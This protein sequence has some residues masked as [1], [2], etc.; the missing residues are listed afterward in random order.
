MRTPHSSRARLRRTLARFN[1]AFANPVMRLVAGWLPPLAIVQHRGRMTGREYATPVIAFGRSDGLVVGV[2]GVELADL[3]RRPGLGVAPAT[4]SGA[5]YSGVAWVAP[6][7][8][9]PLV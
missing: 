3:H 2:M 9:Q 1:R 7:G 8:G 6:A 5:T 4:T